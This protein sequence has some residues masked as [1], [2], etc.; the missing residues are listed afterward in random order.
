MSDVKIND[1]ELKKEIE[2][3]VREKWNEC[4]QDIINCVGGEEH[5]DEAV[6]FFKDTAG[7]RLFDE[8]GRELMDAMSD[9]VDEVLENF[10][11]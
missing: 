7:D 5:W 9:V 11:G 4:G 3:F 8:Y 10:R 1:P 6:E 2:Y